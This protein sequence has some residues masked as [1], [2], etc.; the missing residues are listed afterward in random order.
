M[1][2]DSSVY[3]SFYEIL[4]DTF[5]RNEYDGNRKIKIESP[6]IWSKCKREKNSKGIEVDVGLPIA[7]K[8]FELGEHCFYFYRKNS[9]SQ[10][11]SSLPIRD[12]SLFL[13]LQYIGINHPDILIKSK[14]IKEKT[15]LLLQEFINKN[16]PQTDLPLDKN[17]DETTVQHFKVGENEY[18]SDTEIKDAIL[19]FYRKISE[20]KFHDAWGCL[21]IH[22]Q[23]FGMWRSQDAFRRDFFSKRKQV[24][25]GEIFIFNWKIKDNT[26][27]FYVSFEESVKY[28]PKIKYQ[29]IENFLRSNLSKKSLPELS[30]LLF[31]IDNYGVLSK[32]P[33]TYGISQKAWDRFCPLKN[34]TVVRF[35]QF[36]CV[37]VEGR[38][39]IN[40]IQIPLHLNT[41]LNFQKERW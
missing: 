2:V 15:K 17:I 32:P 26:V 6:E 36:Y 30:D 28:Y 31:Q 22:Y 34:I 8:I 3:Q 38:W 1:N 20:R 12:V 40:D 18:S 35:Y 4:R 5:I 9:E 39:L 13:A 21:T 19:N 37:Y 24:E 16:I 25:V 29:E 10:T 23:S 41:D 14:S 11:K 7:S 33:S 27:L